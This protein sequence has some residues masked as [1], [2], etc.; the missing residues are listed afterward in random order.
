[1]YIHNIVISD[2]LLFFQIPNNKCNFYSSK[3]KL[4]ANITLDPFSSHI[5]SHLVFHNK[6]YW[7][8]LCIGFGYS[9]WHVFINFI[10]VH[11]FIYLKATYTSRTQCPLTPTWRCVAL[12]DPI[13]S[14]LSRPT[15]TNQ[16]RLLLILSNGKGQ[17]HSIS[18]DQA[19][20]WCNVKIKPVLRPVRCKCSFSRQYWFNTQGRGI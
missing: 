4:F 2:L 12:M 10:N 20:V 13:A 17:L 1:M 18:P 5:W 3:S 15:P 11:I 9:N 19:P 6:S 14:F 7:Y 16:D 8:E